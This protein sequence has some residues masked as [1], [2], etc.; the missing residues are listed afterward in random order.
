MLKKFG[1]VGIPNLR[2]LNICLLVSW[3]KTY[4]EGNGKLRK[5]LIAFKYDINRPN[6]L[7]AKDTNSSQVFKEL[8]GWPRQPAWVLGGR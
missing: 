5:E 1:G 8:S 6:I 4:Q 3:I 7:C 2:D